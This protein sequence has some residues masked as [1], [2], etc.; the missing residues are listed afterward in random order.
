MAVREEVPRGQRA[1]V[2]KVDLDGGEGRIGRPDLRPVAQ[3]D[4]ESA[5]GDSAHVGG[6]QSAA[7]GQ[8]AIGPATQQALQVRAPDSL[9]VVCVTE[10][11]VVAVGAGDALDLERDLGI[12][13]V[14]DVGQQQGEGGAAVPREAARQQI[15][16]VVERRDRGMYALA[17]FRADG[18]L[19]ADDVRNGRR[20]DPGP[21]RHIVDRRCHFPSR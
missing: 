20:R 19:A 6:P 18:A 14:G 17:R 10:H 15:G 16:T 11:Q 8:H 4:G 1:A 7:H 13:R 12:E 5:R 3:D 9:I 2:S 21:A